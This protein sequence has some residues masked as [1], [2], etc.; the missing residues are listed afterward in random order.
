VIYLAFGELSHLAAGRWNQKDLLV[1]AIPK[2]FTIEL[3]PSASDHFD[4]TLP[5]PLWDLRTA[6]KC[7]QLPIG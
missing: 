2:P 6:N 7:E 3:V 4:V 5:R 1:A